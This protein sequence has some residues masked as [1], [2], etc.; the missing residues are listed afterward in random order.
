MQTVKL[1]ENSWHYRLARTYGTFNSYKSQDI[2]TY[3]RSMLVGLFFAFAIVTFVTAFTLPFAVTLMNAIVYFQT[4]VFHF[5]E[6]T[7]ASIG[8]VILAAIIAVIATI[9]RIKEKRAEKKLEEM[10]LRI[11]KG[12]PVAEEPVKTRSFFSAWYQKLHDKTCF[13]I[14]LE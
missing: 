8:F 9:E 12:L 13:R 6:M 4:G 1:K 7:M 10:S 3:T 5:D 2:C 11:M 14:E